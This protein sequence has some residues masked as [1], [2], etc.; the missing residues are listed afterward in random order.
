L[1]NKC[2]RNRKRSKRRSIYCLTHHCYLD[3]VSQKYPLFADCAEHLQ[4]RGVSR[5]NAMLLVASKTTVSL[6]G[7]WLE[8]F[9]CDHCQSTSW[10]HVRKTG[11][12][13]YEL[14]IAPPE[15]W[16]NANNV[17]Q[18]QGNPSVGEF[19]RR[20][21]RMLGFNGVKEFQFVV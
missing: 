8:A 6:N 15:L 17:I 9:W 14:A 5:K 21:S 2:A 13:S 16:Q 20:Q 4:Q 19:T 18:A 3:S 10:Y 7:E 11:D 12:R 1:Q